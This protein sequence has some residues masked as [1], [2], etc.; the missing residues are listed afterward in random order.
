MVRVHGV[1]LAV[2]VLVAAAVGVVG[3]LAVQQRA[4]DGDAA[5]QAVADI[6]HDAPPCSDIFVAGRPT[7]EVVADAD[8]IGLCDDAGELQ[9]LVMASYPC[10]A[11]AGTVHYTAGSPNSSGWG[12]D[13]QGWNNF[14]PGEEAPPAD[15][16]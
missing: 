6:G 12:V 7:D 1:L 10:D 3:T 4:E 5:V 11:G 16:C 13:G 8:E 14:G 9:W 2:I 15:A